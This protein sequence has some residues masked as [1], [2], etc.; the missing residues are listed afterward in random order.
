MAATGDMGALIENEPL[1][2]HTSWRIGGPARYYREVR[3]P[4]ALRAAIHW[5]HERDLPLFVLGSGTNLLVT[6]AGFPGLVLRYTGRTWDL[7]EQDDRGVLY[8]EAGAPMAGTARRVSARGWAGLVWAEG[9][10][11]SLG[12]AIYGNAGC[13]GGD[14]A[15][16]VQRVWLL[17]DDVVQVWPVAWLELGYRTSWLKAQRLRPDRPAGSVPPIVLAAELA[18]TQADPHELA[19]TMA[20]IAAL[21]K[22]KTPWGSSCGSVFRNPAPP[23]GAA[24]LSAGQLIDQAG[25]KGTRC[26]GA[27]I[28]EKH[29]NY[30][31]NLGDATSKDILDL[32]ELAQQRVAQEFGIELELEVQVLR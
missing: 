10:P 25:L 12:G 15:S 28:S 22:A 23:P 26:G 2:R 1:A 4:A 3:S 29:G 31:V 21:R 13:Y 7:S 19:V 30:M 27:M 14:M 18:L 8:L 6:E 5:A 16:V 17:V 11:G 20:H 32:I 24:P 9:L